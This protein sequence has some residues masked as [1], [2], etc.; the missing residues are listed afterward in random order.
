MKTSHFLGNQEIGIKKS[1]SLRVIFN[2]ALVISVGL[3]VYFLIFK[4]APVTLDKTQ[5]TGLERAK[6][7]EKERFDLQPVTLDSKLLD[8][9]LK[10]NI[11]EEESVESINSLNKNRTYKVKRASFDSLTQSNDINIQAHKVEVRKSLNYTLC[12]EI[13][14]KKDCGVLAAHIARLLAWSLEVNSQMR[15]GDSLYFVF[16]RLNNEGQLKILQLYY[17]SSYLKKT[18]EANFY[19]GKAMEYGGYFD[20]NGEEVAQRIVK[21]QSPID[22]YIEITSLL[23]DFRK[24]RGGHL[25]TDFKADVGTPI[26]A[27]FDGRITRTSWNRRGNGYCIEIDHP[28]Q[29]VKTRYLHLSRVLVKRGQYVKQGEM[30][31]KSGNTGRSFAPHLHYE[32]RGRGKNKTVYDPFKFKYHKTY[33]RNIPSKFNEEFQKVIS[34]YEAYF[35]DNEVI[36]SIE[37]G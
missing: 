23:G 1:Y 30:I 16:E 34:T 9:K 12:Q 22:K 33:R 8:S 25:G 17:E 35:D 11:H 24:R 26:R 19:K 28:N 20:R 3:N 7:T 37:A 32:I 21:A 14:L 18:I 6:A 27:T 4:S 10:F 5:T 2:L 36:K 31:G 13:Q 29:K 15:N